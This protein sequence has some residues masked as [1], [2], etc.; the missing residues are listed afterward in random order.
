VIAASARRL[1]VFRC[2]VDA[3]GFNAAAARLG[4]AQPS[5]GA[6]IK[7]LETQLGQPLFARQRGTRPQLTAAGEALYAYAIDAL[8]RSAEASQTLADLRGARDVTVAVHRD[9]AP[10]FLSRHLAPF[11]RRTAKTRVVTRIGTIEEVLSLARTGQADI[12]I[13]LADAPVSGVRAEILAREPLAIVVAPAHPLARRKRV[14]PDEID[15]HPFVGGLRDSSYARMMTR[16]LRR[17]G[18]RR[19]EIAMELPESTAVKEM[20]RHGVGAACLPVCTVADELAA[21]TLTALDL[22][23]PLPPLDVSCAWRAPLHEPATA[24]LAHLRRAAA[25]KR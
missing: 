24:L 10:H 15:R 14:S 11:A 9:L 18:L 5:V 12:G 19:Y 6:H 2:V 7:A 23:E 3:G 22:A 16:V 1:S 4:I 13:L 8:K 25:G 17:L 21:G 20:V